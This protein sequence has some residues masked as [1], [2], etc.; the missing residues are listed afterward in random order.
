MRSLIIL[1][2]LCSGWITVLEKEEELARDLTYDRQQLFQ[3]YVTTIG[4]NDLDSG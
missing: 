3:K 1:R 2:A 4:F